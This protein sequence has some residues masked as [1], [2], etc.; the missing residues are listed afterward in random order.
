MELPRLDRRRITPGI[1]PAARVTER[2]PAMGTTDLNQATDVA[3]RELAQVQVLEQ[4]KA[5]RAQL[6]GLEAGLASFETQAITEVSQKKGKDALGVTPAYLTNYDKAADEI[7]KGITSPRVKAAFDEQRIARRT[8]FERGLLRHET[9][10][11][12]VYFDGQTEALVKAEQDA[13]AAN[14]LDPERR[15]GAIDRMTWALNDKADRDGLSKEARD[16]LLQQGRSSIHKS[17]IMGMATTGK[18]SDASAYYN[19]NKTGMSAADIAA[20]DGVVREGMVRSESLRLADEFVAT[21][22]AGGGALKAAKTIEDPEVRKAVEDRVRQQI[23]DANALRNQAEER[24]ADQAWDI[25]EK[26]GGDWSAVPVDVWMTVPG[27]TRE[28]IRNANERKATSPAGW[29]TYY[30]LRSLASAPETQQAFLEKNLMVEAFPYM[31]PQQAKELM[32]LQAGLRAGDA[33]AASVV[34]GVQTEDQIVTGALRSMGLDPNEKSKAKAEKVALFR[35][36]VDE[37]VRLIENQTQKPATTEAVQKVVDSLAIEQTFEG[38]F[39]DK[40]KRAYEITGEDD[41]PVVSTE[42]EYDDLPAGTTFRGPD[43]S[44]RQKP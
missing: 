33:K 31:A 20:V 23:S 36:K 35:R 34:D 6:V 18:Y 30:D 11:K 2:A 44:L 27:P 13:I 4:A 15:Q 37:R 16:V 9:E 1:G 39:Y 29:Q 19:E 38:F 25:V 8:M 7:A 22:G 17:A 26:N 14:P 28:A 10:Q 24:A 12:G 42:A 3:T 41:V 5:D 21:H 40:V 32:D 43:G